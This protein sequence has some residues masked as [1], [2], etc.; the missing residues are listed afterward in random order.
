MVR[1]LLVTFLTFS[2]NDLLS[3]ELKVGFAKISITPD[4]I[5]KWEDIDNDAQFNSNIDLWTDVNGNG[6]FDAVWMA[7]FQNNRPAQGIKDELMAVAAVID[8]GKTRIGI[9]SADTIGLM[10]KFVLSVRKDLPAEWGLDYLMIH[11]T[12]NHEG[13]DTQGLW[14]P[15]L[16]KSGVDDEYMGQLKQNFLNA[17]NLAIDNLEP[18]QMSLALIPTNPLTPI[19]DKRKPIVIDDDIRAVLFSRSDDSS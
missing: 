15:S 11:A 14:G 10:R 1:L 6:Q 12:H 2:S 3:N 13:P 8:D 17:L 19:K 4:I 16:F 7:G 9:I 5:D 18:A